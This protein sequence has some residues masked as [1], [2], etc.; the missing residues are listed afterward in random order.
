MNLALNF[1]SIILE[2]VEAFSGTLQKKKNPVIVSDPNIYIFFPYT[3][4]IM[5]DMIKILIFNFSQLSH[6]YYA[7]CN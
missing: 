1:T 3:N 2:K 4:P 5:T 7:S 6:N